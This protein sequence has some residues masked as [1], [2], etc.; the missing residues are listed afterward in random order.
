MK[1][2]GILTFHRSYNYGAFMQCYALVNKIKVD[3]PDVLVEVI[4]YTPTSTLAGYEKLKSAYADSNIADMIRVQDGLF[5]AA[6]SKYLPLSGYKL[7]SEDYRELFENIKGKYDVIIVG[8]DAVWNWGKKGFPNAYYLGG[9]LN[10]VKMSYA[11]SA[12]GMDYKSM[13]QEQ[14][15]QLKELINDFSYIGVREE[16]AAQMVKSVDSSLQTYRN[17]DPTVLLDI[18]KIPVDMDQ[19]REKLRS[20]GIDFTKPIIGLMAGEPYGKMIKKYYGDKVQ[21]VALYTPNRYADFFLYDLDPLEW[22][23][24]FSFFSVTITH[25]FHGTMLSLRNLTPV[26]PIERVSEYTSNYT[27][28]IK[29]AMINLELEDY[30]ETYKKKTALVNKVLRKL[31][32][33]NDKA[34]WY[35]ICKK[36]DKIMANPPKERI[37]AAMEKEA[38]TYSSFK[39]KLEEILN[40]EHENGQ[41]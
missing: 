7:I 13:T 34:F 14:K 24:V 28:K 10:A 12:H 15:K 4:D 35:G 8:S 20:K 36:I 21:T 39:I 18:E 9:N 5:E 11:A 19:L 26:I 32:M 3:F 25:F 23:R 1:K 30:Y 31:K 27:T 22:T 37:R 16:T 33:D 6:Q 29:S 40:E 2:I 41:D 38:E 17:C